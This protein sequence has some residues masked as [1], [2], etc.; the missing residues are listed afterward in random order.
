MYSVETRNELLVFVTL[1]LLCC[2]FEQKDLAGLYLRCGL[3]NLGTVFLLTDA[4][5]PDEK[6]LVLIN[7]LLASGEIA[8]LFH[9]DEVENIV[10]SVRNEVNI[11]MINRRIIDTKYVFEFLLISTK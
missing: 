1:N 4:L 2:N 7:D 3:K 11:C 9:D 6:F 5:I 10:G 8:D